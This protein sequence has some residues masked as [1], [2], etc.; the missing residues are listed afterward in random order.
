LSPPPGLSRADEAE[1]LR[2][3][4]ALNDERLE[5]TG[6]PEIETRTRAYEMA[7]RMQMRAPEAIDL[8]RET[9]ATL[10]LY[11]VD[12]DQPS[13]A[14][15]CLLARRLVERGVRFVQ[16]YHTNWDHHGGPG[17]RIDVDLDRCA[18]EVDRASRAL[19][20]D[21]KARGLLEDTLVVWSGEFGRTPLGE[22]RAT[23]GRDHHIE[24]FTCWLA[25]GGVRAGMTHGATDELGFG[26]LHGRVHIHD[27]QATVLHLLGIEHTRLTY[28]FQGRDYR[29]TDVGGNVVREI[30][31]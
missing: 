16:L 25:G 19:I 11:G 22:V 9:P 7:F 15:N 28:R 31:S 24:A 3:V 12:P 18:R 29:L 13:F 21:L 4:R 2:A 1:F 17:E 26:P 5:T 8:R 27:L 14:K 20:L 10:D 30:L 6:D 23:T